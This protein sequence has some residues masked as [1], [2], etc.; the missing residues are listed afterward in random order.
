M[1]TPSIKVGQGN[2]GIKTGNLLAYANTEKKFSPVEF[3]STRALSTATRVNAS[4]DI[5]GV[6]ANVPRIDY[7]GGQA[8]L[9]VEPSGTNSIW[10]ST[11]SASGW[12]LNSSMTSAIIDVIG[13]SGVNLTVGA[14]GTIGG[15][16]SN[17]ASP[18]ASPVISLVSGSTYTVSFFTKKTTAHTFVAYYMTFAGAASGSI[19]SGFDVSGSF[20]SGSMGGV[21][22]TAGVTNRIRRVERWGTDVFRCSETFTMTAS[23]TVARI[24]I[25]I[26]TGA[27]SQTSAPTGTTIGFAAP[28]IELGS[29]PTSFIPT[30][31]GSV[32]RNADVISLTGV[33]GLIGQTEG[34]IYVEVDIRNFTNSARIIALSDGTGFNSIPL[35]LLV[36]GG[37]NYI[38]VPINALSS[39]QADI[40]ASMSTGVYKIA[41]GYA[42]NNVALYLNGT[43][44]G[45][46]TSC[47][48]PA[49]NKLDL[50]SLNGGTFFNNRI[51]AVSI[52]QTRLPNTTT[53]GSPSLQS[54]TTL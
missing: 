54:I 34:T 45:T 36:D 28:Q 40:I 17:Y 10:Q 38:R 41:L 27:S 53:D 4:G 33:A 46:D 16:A 8:S 39:P 43:S 51:R 44:V 19:G 20:S 9:L 3:T 35:Q 50:G 22:N 42:Q 7:L 49:T 5:E 32:T 18:V 37:L 48:M 12:T 47:I 23:G 2:W 24:N 30:T 13:V 21:Y 52:Y 1:S 14:S 6:N 29:V 26:P 31:T 15:G 11:D 25:A